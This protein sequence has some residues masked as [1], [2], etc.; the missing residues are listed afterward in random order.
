MSIFLTELSTRHSLLTK[1][2]TF[3]DEGGRLKSNADKMTGTNDMPIEVQDDTA[4]VIMRE[5]SDEQEGT[6]DLA[7]VPAVEDATT[8]EA[9]TGRDRTDK[10][11]RQSSDGPLVSGN[12]VDDDNVQ[13]QQTPPS[14]PKRADAKNPTLGYRDDVGDDKKKLALNT[15]YEG[16]SIYGRI[17]CLVGKRRGPV[18]GKQVAAGA[19]QAMMEGWIASTQVDRD[20]DD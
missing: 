10:R 19:G 8:D 4:P 12:A 18:R 20:E 7:D 15:S 17:L 9:E 14:K 13:T 16:F 6:L 1:Q 2:K 11:R 3:K 5:E